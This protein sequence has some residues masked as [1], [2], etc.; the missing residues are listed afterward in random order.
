MSW[1][2]EQAEEE[3]ARPAWV[4][5]NDMFAKELLATWDGTMDFSADEWLDSD[6]L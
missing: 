3:I 2:E 4:Q 1:A 5:V 6:G